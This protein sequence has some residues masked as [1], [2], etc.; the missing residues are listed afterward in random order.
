MVQEL[1][2]NPRGGSRTPPGAGTGGGRKR[3]RGDREDGSK[4]RETHIETWLT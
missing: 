1:D 4:K 2:L 3:G